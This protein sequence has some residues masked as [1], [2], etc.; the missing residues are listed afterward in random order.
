MARLFNLCL[1]QGSYPWNS[2]II[3][4]LL[5]SGD[6]HNPDN[7]RAIAV[8]SCLGKTFSSILLKRLLLFRQNFCPDPPSQLGFCKGA[9]TNDHILSLKTV[10]D[11]HYKCNKNKKKR[12]FACFVDLK[13]AFDNVSRDLLLYKLSKVN[14][15]GR[16]FSVIE[17]MYKKSTAR[18]KINNMLTNTISIEKGTEQGHPMSPELF[19]IFIRD[20]SQSLSNDGA[21]P[22]LANT[23]IT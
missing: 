11:K 1:W 18:I 15:K 8:G 5:K 2:S 12:L 13:K 9:Q 10:I 19:K 6:K 16:F 3:T 21:Y 22:E 14:V 17:S 4:P 7:Y 23:L 20:L